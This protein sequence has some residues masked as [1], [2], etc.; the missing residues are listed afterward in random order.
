MKFRSVATPAVLLLFA[1]A[2]Q[3]QT[4]AFTYQGKLNDGGSPATGNYDFRFRLFDVS[5]NVVAGPITNAPVGVTNGQ[6]AATLN[7]GSAVFDGSDRWLE[8]AVRAYGDTNIAYT[9][10]L[11]LQPITS[12]PY[13][14]RAINAASATNAMFLTSPL[15]GTNVVGVI[16]TANLPTNVAF[17]N[18]NQTFSGSQT[19]SSAVT[20]NNSANTFSGDGA[21][22][23][24]LAATNLTGTLPDARL[25]P[26]VALQSN[27]NLSFAGSVSATNFIGAGHGLTNVPGAFFWV[28]VTANVQSYPNVGYICSNNVT[29]VKVT[30]PASPSVGDTFKVAGIGAAGWIIA[31]NAGQTILAG[32]I[33]DSA[34]QSWKAAAS[35]DNWTAIASSAD[36]TKLAA[37]TAG[38]AIYTS[39]DSGA[40]WAQRATGGGNLSCIASSADGTKLIMGAGYTPH[41]STTGYIYTSSNS[42]INWTTRLGPAAWSGVAS[43]ADGSRLVA[44]VRG[45]TIYTSA[46]SGGSWS[47]PSGMSTY[48][49]SSVAS[50]S[51]GAKLV[52]VEGNGWILTSTDYGASWTQRTNV[53]PV[54]LTSVASSLD[55]T[56]LIAT[57]NG[58]QI[59]VSTD[60]GATW[61]SQVSPA[62]A[63]LT[64]VAS[65]SDG[66]RLA[67]TVGGSSISG[68]IYGSSDSGSIWAQ[69][70][71]APTASWSGIASSAD[72]SVLAATVYGGYIYV[73][74]QNSTTSG[75]TGYLAGGEHSAIELIYVGGG[76][77][78]PLNHEG[79]IRAY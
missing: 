53:A 34:G 21:G 46:D 44:V 10:L 63:Q 36:G 39:T 71:G 48:L 62:A 20:A 58:G 19:F 66:G 7:F 30:L 9:K 16:P 51:S 1:V 4:T 78:L 11:P 50:S 65:S 38:G 76:T 26:N 77:F 47:S 74:S 73:S 61:T 59:Y 69:L 35:S 24:N 2:V 60:S 13:A 67:T 42:G 6:F 70:T 3:A 8:I 79:T 12:V 23:K 41:S 64:S 27:P 28:T 15:P 52:A 22:L 29:P 18:S 14:I 54:Q 25:T 37:T 49:W 40:N 56:R 33:A 17:L 43:S 32:N 72:G 57:G 45:G 75:A 5:S 31:Q 68:N 55:G